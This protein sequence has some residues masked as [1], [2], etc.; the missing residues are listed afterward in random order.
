MLQCPALQNYNDVKSGLKKLKVPL[1]P[2]K[3]KIPKF[4]GKYK[5]LLLYYNIIII[6]I[7]AFQTVHKVCS[8]YLVP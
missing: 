7:K 6:Y 4:V 2:S 8:W 1:L 5:I 3:D